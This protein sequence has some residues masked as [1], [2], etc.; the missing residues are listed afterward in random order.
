MDVFSW[1][2][3][4]VAEKVTE[5]LIKT[6]EAGAKADELDTTATS[7]QEPSVEEVHAKLEEGKQEQSSKLGPKAE[8]WKK[9]VK[10][11]SRML[12]ML[13]TI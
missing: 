4:F 5:M 3:P 12:K 9:K 1:S 2:I 6:L 7:S 10:T 13:K 8:M 11:M